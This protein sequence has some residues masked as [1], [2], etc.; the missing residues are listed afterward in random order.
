MNAQIEQFNAWTGRDVADRVASS[1]AYR[2]RRENER[3]EG[4]YRND[5]DLDEEAAPD[6][7]RLGGIERLRMVASVTLRSAAPLPS[8]AAS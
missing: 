2:A 6:L 1:S 3:A 7:D 5:D 8:T 4:A